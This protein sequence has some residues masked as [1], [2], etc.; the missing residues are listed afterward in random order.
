M[1]NRLSIDPLL[2]TLAVLSG[3]A[4]Y[5]QFTGDLQNNLA[6]GD[7]EAALGTLKDAD[8]GANRLLFLLE[9]G[10]VAH[11]RG[12]Y[13]QSNTYFEQAERLADELF[14]R[15]LSRE[16]AALVT[17]DAVRA[18]RGEEYELVFIHYYRALNYWRLRLPEDALVECRKANLKL[19]RYTSDIDYETSYRNDA[20]IHYLTGLFYE[21]TGELNDAYV[22]YRDAAKAYAVYEERLGVPAPAPLDED[23][24]RMSEIFDST[25]VSTVH[26]ASWGTASLSHPAGDGELVLF[27]ETGFIPRKIQEEINLP[28]F[29]DDI[30]KGKSG[31]ISVVSQE[32]A[33]RYRRSYRSAKVEYWLRVAL[34][35]YQDTHPRVASVSLRA[36]GKSTRAVPAENLA[37]I[38]RSTFHDKQ[39]VILARTVVRGFAKYLATEGVKK[40]SKVLGFFANLL[41]A[42]TEAADTRSWVSLP[43]TIHIAKLRLPPGVHDI[44]VESRDMGGNLVEQKIVEGVQILPGERTFLNVRSYK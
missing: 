18:Y 40:K 4:T 41:A 27:A 32:I 22:S 21:A 16:V 43:H 20:F 37:A 34:P 25:G 39:P 1:V 44:T 29:G 12:L 35:V 15:S 38:A 8:S 11:D 26:L 10:L 33:W 6:R 30:R 28:I 42:S 5:A 19:A 14:T 9:N 13:E 31:D 23:L 17:N 3:C 7:Y 2:L 24:R 36:S